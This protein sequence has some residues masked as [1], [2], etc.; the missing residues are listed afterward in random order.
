M[1]QIQVKDLTFGYDGNIQNVFEN[2]SFNLDTDWKL[3]LIGRNGKGKT[4]FFNLLLGKYKYQGNI[5]GN[6]EFEYFPYEIDDEND[7]SINILYNLLPN[8]EDWKIYKELN[9]LNGDSEILYRSFNTLSGGEK[10]KILLIGLFLKENKF[11]LIDEPTNHL[12]KETKNDVEKYLK[13]KK[14]YIIVSHD[15][16]LLDSVVDHIISINKN[17]IDIQKGN[18]SSWK[19]N[20]DNQDKFEILQ[21]QNLEKSINKLENAISKTENWSKAIE[22]TKYGDGHVDKGYIGHQSSRMMQ[23]SKAILKRKEAEFDKKSTL[24]K[25]LEKQEDLKIKPLK[26]EKSNLII[27]SKL[28]ITYDGKA[29]FEPINF[30]VQNG[31]RIAIIGKN[32]S[33][34]SSIL[35]LILQN[36]IS[37]NGEIRVS[38]DLIISYVSQETNNLKGSL[39]KYIEEN[40]I[41]E[42]IFKAM[43]S[44]LGFSNLDFDKEIN[45]LSEGQ[46]KKILIA[47]SIS[48]SAHIYIWDEPLNFVDII[49]REQIEKVILEYN[50]TMI[51]VEHDEMF[52]E[53]IATKKLQLF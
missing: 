53:K 24:L 16:N 49:S 19:T 33:G 14:G 50:P 17:N 34:K 1:A 20:K 39:K 31:D 27:A 32:G 38:N 35:K 26:Y 18:Y 45:K 12:D 47:K 28:Q 40:N 2:V 9:L 43:L 52:I 29:I 15:R 30:N 7:I 21:N 25:N 11:L 44:K 37:Y 6:I 4:T 46:K 22:K 48:E 8:V 13:S 23:R 36:E 10:I 41:N 42:P 51:F 3:G 5:T